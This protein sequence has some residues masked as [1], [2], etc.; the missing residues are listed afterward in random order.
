MNIL[1]VDDDVATRALLR[2]ILEK[3][4][5]TVVEAES[6]P[7]A[8]HYLEQHVVDL[9][10]TD[11]RMPEMNGLEF[12]GR[13]KK[14]PDTA[15]IPVLVCTG[16]NDDVVLRQIESLGV[17]GIIQKPINAATV[18]QMIGNLQHKGL[19]VLEDSKLTVQ[20]LGVDIKAYYELLSIM[21]DNAFERLI[22]MKEHA[23]SAHFAGFDAFLRDLYASAESLGA[24]ALSHAAMVASMVIPEAEKEQSQEYLHHLKAEIK[25]L[26]DTVTKLRQH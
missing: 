13:L 24:K 8:F 1:V 20:R 15:D 14:A 16:V 18:L 5:Q 3:I 7:Q 4:E 11:I 22:D 9:I 26:Q 25:R 12:L 23:N 6:G 21:V 19:P 10:I 17:H 2:M